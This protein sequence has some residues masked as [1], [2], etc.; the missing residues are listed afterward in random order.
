MSVAAFAM[1][2]CVAVVLVCFLLVL[3]YS[4]IKCSDVDGRE[5]VRLLSQSESQSSTSGMLLMTVVDISSSSPLTRMG[6]P[7]T[8]LTELA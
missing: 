1:L 8:T 4:K 5:W 2:L 6:K 3:S 7:C